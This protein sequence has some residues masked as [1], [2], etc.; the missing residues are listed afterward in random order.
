MNSFFIHMEMAI[1][2]DIRAFTLSITA[3]IIEYC[4]RCYENKFHCQGR[5][6]FMPFLF[7]ELFTKIIKMIAGVLLSS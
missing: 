1:R 3:N 6:R 7:P 2:S 4:A 5:V